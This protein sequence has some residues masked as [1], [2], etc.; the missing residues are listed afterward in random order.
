[1]SIHN[2]SGTKAKNNH[3]VACGYNSRPGSLLSSVELGAEATRTGSVVVDGDSADKA[4]SAGSFAYNNQAPVAKRLTKKL[5]GVANAV[6]LK[7]ADQPALVDSIHEVEGVTTNK[8]AT[9]IRAGY[10]NFYSGSW[11]TPPAVSSDSFGNDNAARVSRSNPGSLT[12]KAGKPAANTVG[13]K[14]KTN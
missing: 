9:A 1:M 10:L 5:S 14:A 12:Y 2:F 4:V 11:S 3:G 7:A 8:T 13:Y 6:L